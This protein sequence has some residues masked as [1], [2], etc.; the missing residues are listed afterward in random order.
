MVE[1]IDILIEDKVSAAISHKLDDMATKAKRAYINV[2]KLAKE[3]LGL[4]SNSPQKLAADMNK[5][6]NAVE[7]QTKVQSSLVAS[8][9]KQALSQDK[10]NRSWLQTETA[11]QRGVAAETRAQIAQQKL[12]NESKK[13]DIIQQRLASEIQKTAAAQNRTAASAARTAAAEDRARL[14]ALRLDNA[15]KKLNST[16]KR[17]DNDFSGFIRTLIAYAG[18]TF[19]AREL[20]NI[21][22]TYT[23]LQNKIKNV[24]ESEGQLT[25][26]T[27]QVF[28]VANET[29]T[30]IDATAN[31]FQRFDR[32]LINLGASQTESI[33]LTK[34]INELLASGGA[35][36][37]EQTAGLLQLSQAF[38]KGKLDA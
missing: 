22:D 6:S 24:T 13:G 34:T 30:E 14:T 11:L 32:A 20:L 35:T 27:K 1:R 23:L 19:G 7:K 4:N 8:T 17:T 16:V 21:G 26:V 29:R 25:A 10:L 31:A 28:D 3:L 38:N 2:E 18:I 15:H 9:E 5:L 33:R 37:G 36:T 12:N